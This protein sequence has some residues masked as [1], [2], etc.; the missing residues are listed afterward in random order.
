MESRDFLVVNNLHNSN[1]YGLYVDTPPMLAMAAQKTNVINIPGREESLY[2]TLDEYEDVTLNVKAYSFSN[3]YDIAQVYMWLRTAKR[4][5]FNSNP[6][7]WFKVKKVNAI[8]PN[9]SGHGKNLYTLSF[10]IS[11]FRY[12]SDDEAISSRN[13]TFTVENAGNVFCRPVY[14]IY[15]QGDISI[16][17]VDS[18]GNELE[19]LE[20]FSVNGECMID[21]ERLVVYKDKEL[22]RTSGKIPLLQVG[23]NRFRTTG[24][25]ESIT[26]RRYQREV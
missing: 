6:K 5:S 7:Y 24:N 13:A 19:K 26:L 22:L 16:A 15:A 14:T 20:I 23:T 18:E 11:P 9:Y 12:L 8:T 17:T 25:I 2:Q 10:V 1:E 3:D 21:S 4:I